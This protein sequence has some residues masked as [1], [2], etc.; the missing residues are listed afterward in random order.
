MSITAE[1]LPPLRSFN[2]A[3][4]IFAQGQ[5]LPVSMD[6][7]RSLKNDARFVVHGLEDPLL[8]IEFD[9]PGRL[10]GNA[11]YEAIVDASSELDVDDEATF[12]DKGRFQI[13]A[14]SAKLGF[15]ITVRERDQ[16]LNPKRVPLETAETPAR[17]RAI[18]PTSPGKLTIKRASAAKKE[19]LLV[20]MKTKAFPPAPVVSDISDDQD[21]STEGAIDA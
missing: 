18:A 13:A 21:D 9:K 1:L 2:K 20:A 5:P 14:L 10:S 7:A 6:M 11:L 3:G 15:D 16:A 8:A 17:E 4:T 19:E 12:D